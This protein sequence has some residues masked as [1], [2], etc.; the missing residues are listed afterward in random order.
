MGYLKDNPAEKIKT[1]YGYFDKSA[2]QWQQK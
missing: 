1:E 2:P